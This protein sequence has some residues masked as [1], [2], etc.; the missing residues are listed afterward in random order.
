MPIAPAMP[1]WPKTLTFAEPFV[2]RWGDGIL[3]ADG[4]VDRRAVARRV[5]AK[6]HAGTADRKFLEDLLH[7]RIRQRLNQ[8]RDEAAASGK[9][10]RSCSTHRSCW[11]PAG[12]RCATSSS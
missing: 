1:F 10:G 4:R 2:D 9:A 5:F 7:P 11:K 3:D 12:A 8:Q 6:S